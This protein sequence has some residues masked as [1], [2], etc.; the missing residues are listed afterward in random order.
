MSSK[1]EKVPRAIQGESRVK[2]G[3]FEES[4]LNNWSTS[5]SQKGGRNQVSGRGSVP[6]WH[7]HTRCKCYMETIHNYVKVMKWVESLI[8][9]EVTVGQGS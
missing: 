2:H 9:S 3:K 1:I 6:C 4:G 7:C 8:G 5:K